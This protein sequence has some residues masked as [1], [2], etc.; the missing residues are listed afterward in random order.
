[1]AKG[2]DQIPLKIP[3]KWDAEWF[4]KFVREVLR[5]AD[6]RNAVPGAG[7]TITG[8]SAEPATISADADLQNLLV[9]PFVVAVPSGF[10]QNER[11]LTGES[12]VID[13]DDGGPDSTI[14]VGLV[15]GSLPYSKFQDLPALSVLGNQVDAT[16]PVGA[17]SGSAQYDVLAVHSDGGGGLFMQFGPI[18]HNFISDFAE[19]AQDAV[20]TIF[21][22]SDTIDFTYDDTVPSIT[23]VTVQQMSIT[24]DASGLML[25]GDAD[26]PGNSRYYGTDSSGTK[27]F[28]PLS[29]GGSDNPA[30]DI[31]AGLVAW[32]SLDE[33]AANP[34]YSDSHASN[35]LTQR[36]AAGSVNTSVNST[37]T[38]L[39]GR[40]WNANHTDDLTCYIPRAN[41]NLDAIDTDFTFGGWFRT[42]QDVATAA[43]IM[44]RVGDNTSAREMWLSV[45]SAGNITLQ[46]SADGSTSTTVNSGIAFNTTT[47]CFITGT[48]DKT[49]GV[50]TIRHRAVGAPYMTRI[51]A[52]FPGPIYTGPS[53]SN[54]CISEGL[55]NDNSFFTSN[56][57][58]VVMADECFYT[59]MEFEDAHFDYL[60]NYGVAKTYALLV[61]DA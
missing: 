26:A 21:V 20:G 48:Y 57:G 13:I 18:D 2:I 7:I 56:R 39:R 12:G 58:G 29:G 30:A 25:V 10:L 45:D 44:G 23:A 24:S 15:P 46:I 22:D 34:T 60:Y 4:R 43:F 40:A 9:Q 54:F 35:D 16:G 37:T 38:A 47:Y 50:A 28:Y 8:D 17:I 1:M 3:L 19:A 53:T 51:S 31:L 11:V 49:N 5:N 14:T 27:G 41:T 42:N 6:V 61:A 33:N 32:W 36:N 59:R 55:A 52:P